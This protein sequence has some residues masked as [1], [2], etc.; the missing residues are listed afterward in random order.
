MNASVL[1]SAT[2]ATPLLF[3]W[4]P[5]G[6]RKVAITAFLA[7][8]LI[9][10]AFCFYLFQIVY[11]P[12]VALLPPP[13]RVSLISPNSEEG[14]TLLRWVEAEDPALAFSTQR[15][16]EARVHALPKMDHVPSY[17]ATEPALKEVPP[18]EVD[19]RI[20]TSQPP[21]AVPIFHPQS[22]AA[23]S[24]TPTTVS[25]S[26]EFDALGI[27]SFPTLKFTASNNEPAQSVRFR[28]AVGPQREIRYCFPLN[29]SGD[30]ALDEQARHYLMLCRFSE[31]PTVGA[32]NGQPLIWGMATVEW[33]SDVA[34]LRATAT[35]PSVP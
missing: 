15:P 1:G 28:I 34:L 30:P 6:R 23:T 27:P 31:R 35:T 22:V 24:A 18:A 8:S 7:A 3:D 12:T 33:G 14:R 26:K 16:P 17:V 2:E 32:N 20:P 4:E 9:A 10:H 29:S 21:S 5:P 13:A 19:L 25:F 11:P